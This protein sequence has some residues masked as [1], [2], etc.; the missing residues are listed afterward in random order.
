MYC[1]MSCYSEAKICIKDNTG[2]N[3][4]NTVDGFSPL[5]YDTLKIEVDLK[6]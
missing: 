6:F 4:R 1:L 3:K 2:I 5:K